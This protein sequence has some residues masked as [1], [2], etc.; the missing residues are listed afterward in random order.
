MTKIRFSSNSGVFGVGDNGN[1]QGG[2]LMK[3]V[4][5]TQQQSAA[6]GQKAR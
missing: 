5:A 6:Q 4:K 2:V 3:A 1:Y